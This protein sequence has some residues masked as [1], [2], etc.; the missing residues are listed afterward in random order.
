MAS[1][2]KMLRLHRRMPIGRILGSTNL[3]IA[4]GKMSGALHASQFER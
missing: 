1:D 3:A 4:S 2:E